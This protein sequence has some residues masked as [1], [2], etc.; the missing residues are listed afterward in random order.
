MNFWFREEL[1][2]LSKEG[3]DTSNIRPL[4]LIDIDTLI[5]N[6]DVFKHKKL[7]FEDVLIDY[8]DNYIDFSVRGRKYNSRE[9]AIQ[10]QKNSLIPFGEFLDALVD[11]KGMRS[12]PE[13]FIEKAYSM[14]D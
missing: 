12:V 8:Q 6:K 5:Y 14:F 2:K 7:S 11:S 10:A 13:E 4:V 1:A 3:F 9:A